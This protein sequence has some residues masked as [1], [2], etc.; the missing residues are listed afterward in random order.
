[1]KLIIFGGKGRD[2]ITQAEIDH[3]LGLNNRIVELR[4]ARDISVENILLRLSHGAQVE[5]GAHTAELVEEVRCAT[6]RQK[7][8]LR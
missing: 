5:P 8:K 6:R 3:V 1:M 2:S 7:V 4:R